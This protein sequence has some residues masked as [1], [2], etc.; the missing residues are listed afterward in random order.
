MC[1]L[2]AIVLAGCAGQDPVA[3][4]APVAPMTSAPTSVTA[5]SA[6]PTVKPSARP[7]STS[8]DALGAHRVI[9]VP[10]SVAQQQNHRIVAVDG[11][12][13]LLDSEVGNQPRPLLL[14][15]AGM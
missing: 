14:V 4:R 6:A 9:P 7:T 2:S 10:R 11:Q 5:T 13:V 1:L 12:P 3:H 8:P 15:L